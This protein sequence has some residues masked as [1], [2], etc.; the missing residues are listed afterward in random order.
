LDDLPAVEKEEL[1][2]VSSGVK[3]AFFSPLYARPYLIL[4]SFIE[5]QHM[6]LLRPSRIRSFSR[7]ADSSGANE[8]SLG[9]MRLFA[10]EAEREQEKTSDFNA[11]AGNGHSSRPLSVT[12]SLQKNT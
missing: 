4:A 11:G 2:C 8:L 12:E 1:I 3:E 9:R 5:A 10:K 6:P 7:N